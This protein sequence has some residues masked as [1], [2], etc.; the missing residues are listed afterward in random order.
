MSLGKLLNFLKMGINIPISWGLKTKRT[1]DSGETF[2]LCS[3]LP[4]LLQ[5]S[6]LIVLFI[7]FNKTFVFL[8]FLAKKIES[9]NESLVL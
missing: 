2:I 4:F 8:I 6:N 9:K 3:P 5:E 1:L 7:I